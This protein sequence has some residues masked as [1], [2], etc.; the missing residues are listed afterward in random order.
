[1]NMKKRTAS[2]PITTAALIVAVLALATSTVYFA[3]QG[4]TGNSISSNTSKTLSDPYFYKLSPV[5]S[6]A[7]A[8]TGDSLSTADS[9]TV[10]GTGGVTYTPN[11]ALVSVSVVKSSTTAEEATSSNAAATL[12]VIKALN[13]IGIS[14][15]SIETQGYTLST[16][17]AD[18]Y[19]SCIPQITGY[20]VTNSLQVNITSASPSQLGLEAGRVI[21]TTVAA[22]ANQISLTFS[23]TNSILT[24]LINGALQQAVASAYG[25]AQVMASSLGVNI[26][27]VLS[28]SEGSSYTP[29]YGSQ[30]V[31]AAALNTVSTPI[32]P[33]TQS[34][35]VSVQVVYAIS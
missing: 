10:S 7:E 1:M 28:A 4:R 35:S 8:Q 11:E 25:Q 27:G 24:E 22:G 18:C 6:G 15:S 2:I 5:V 26:T 33:G 29:Y 13:G 21:D 31:Y 9:I 12:D 19:S 23:E 32:L 3:Y 30:I 16:D 34:M 14:N 20:T 17:Y